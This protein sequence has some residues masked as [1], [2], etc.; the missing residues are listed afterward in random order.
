MQRSYQ[1]ISE[2]HYE[3]TGYVKPSTGME[4]ITNSAREETDHLTKDDVVIVCGVANNIAKN[5]SSKELK[6]MTHFIQ[7]R[8]NTY[9]MITSTPHRFNLKEVSSIMH[10]QGGECV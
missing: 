2:I 6:Y 4:V 8:R 10:K 9:V 1:V 7:S 3:V 5:Y